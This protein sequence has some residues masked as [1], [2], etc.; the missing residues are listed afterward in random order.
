MYTS[1]SF[2]IGEL[3]RH[4]VAACDARRRERAGQNAFARGRV[5]QRRSSRAAKLCNRGSP[6]L[7]QAE[8]QPYFTSEPQATR[9]AGI[10]AVSRFDEASV[11]IGDEVRCFAGCLRPSLGPSGF[12]SRE[13]RAGA[14][15]RATRACAVVRGGEF[16]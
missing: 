11:Q 12:H 9:R 14:I 2:A 10:A 3:D 16:R 1:T 6:L 7:A 4:V 13:T 5:K 8:V 15:V